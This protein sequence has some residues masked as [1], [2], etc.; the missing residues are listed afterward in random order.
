MFETLKDVQYMVLITKGETYCVIKST[1]GAIWP[2]AMPF[3][4]KAE[5]ETYIQAIK[6]VIDHNGILFERV[7]S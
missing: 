1:E 5:A 3:K 7:R 4:T 6:T 2:T